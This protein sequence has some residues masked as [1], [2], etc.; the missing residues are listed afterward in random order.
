M[1]K[2]NGGDIEFLLVSSTN[3]IEC[4]QRAKVSFKFQLSNNAGEDIRDNIQPEYA[5][6]KIFI[7]TLDP[8]IYQM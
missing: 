1:R 3:T 8:L 4:L 5:A 7:I 2:L 6:L